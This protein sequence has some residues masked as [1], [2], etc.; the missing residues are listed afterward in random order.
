MSPR[1]HL[2]TVSLV[3]LAALASPDRA[4]AAPIIT[5]GTGANAAAIQPTVDAFRAAVGG[6]DNGNAPGTV[7][8]RREINWD[9]GGATGTAAVGT[10]FN[11]FQNNRGALFTTPGTGFV[12]ATPAGLDAFFGRTDGLYNAIF[13]PFSPSRVFTPVGSTITDATFFIPGT[14]GAVPATVSAFGVI[15]LDV[16]SVNVTSLQFF[17]QG[18]ASLGTF[19][20]PATGGSNTFSFLGVRFDAG[21]RVARVRIT[22]GNVILGPTNTALDQVAMDDFIFSEPQAAAVPEPA[23]LA[24]LGVGAAGLAAYRRRRVI[25]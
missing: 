7:G 21:E 22:S 20:A 1:R 8:G 10:P 3:A 16:D 15:F 9:G 23:S 6:P 17:D 2:G 4:G 5:S 24:L 25:R 19:F 11:G 12:Q 14:G 18:G 13:D